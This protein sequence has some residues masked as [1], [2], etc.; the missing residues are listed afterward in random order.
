MN[1]L[2]S[3]YACAPH[4][5]SEYG[6]GWTWVTG[7]RRLGHK[8]WAL[9][10]PVYRELILDTCASDPEL[11]DIDWTFPEVPGWALRPGL[12]PRHE[13]TYNLLWQIQ[14]M[15]HGAAIVN[16]ERIDAIHHAS[17]AGIRAPSFLGGLGPPLIMGPIGGGETSPP[18][19]RDL[20]GVR[21]RAL[22]F[23]RDLSNRTI[24]INPIVRP[25]LKQ[26]AALFVATPE[27]DRLFKGRLS[28]KTKV[29]SQLSLPHLPTPRCR[30]SRTGAPTFIFAGRLL[31]WKGV[32]IALRAFSRVL[33]HYPTARFTV[34]GDGPER[35]RLRK[36]AD[37][38][39]IE[40][41]VEFLSRIPQRSLFELYD[42]HDFMLFPSLH[43]S[44]GMAALEAMALGLPVVCLD[45]GGPGL[46]VNAASGLVIATARRGTDEVAKAM[47]EAILEALEQHG[48]LQALSASAIQ[49]AAEFA[50]ER[51]V[52]ALYGEIAK[53]IS[54]SHVTS[55]PSIPVQCENPSC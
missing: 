29:F 18:G 3:A 8:V 28:A 11:V 15:R 39:G 19:L 23:L 51:R 45:L 53:V 21:A 36:E 50:A 26:A 13:R 6:V 49:R 44:G 9:A 30:G 38:L 14:A 17:W 20:I 34:V 48:R 31:Y 25:A 46:L 12:E 16:R 35:K 40:G 2:V 24:T 37:A 52:R 22:E 1:L 10:S 43:D 33:T 27:T 42:R 7:A 5:G 47:A 41:Q 32:H 4:L 54:T 55:S